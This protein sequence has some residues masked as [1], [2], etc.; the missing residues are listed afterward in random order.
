MK[1]PGALTQETRAEKQATRQ[2]EEA[3]PAT[4]FQAVRHRAPAVERPYRLQTSS[5]TR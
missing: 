2:V 1:M 5:T 4:A 3:F